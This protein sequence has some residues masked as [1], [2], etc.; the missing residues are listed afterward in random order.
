VKREEKTDTKKMATIGHRGRE[1]CKAPERKSKK[2]AQFEASLGQV[3]NVMISRG[4]GAPDTR[5]ICFWEQFVESSFSR[6]SSMQKLYLD[7]IRGR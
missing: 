4:T 3:K 2:E 7:M 1:I 5:I 6:V